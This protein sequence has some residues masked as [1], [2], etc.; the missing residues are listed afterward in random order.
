[1]MSKEDVTLKALFN[2]IDAVNLDTERFSLLDLETRNIRDQLKFD[3]SEVN[4]VNRES[5]RED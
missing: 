1:M 5:E 2:L 4:R 3:L